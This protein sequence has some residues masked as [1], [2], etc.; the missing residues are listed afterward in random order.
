MCFVFGPGCFRVARFF[1]WKSVKILH[2]SKQRA[3]IVYRKRGTTPHKT[4]AMNPFEKIQALKKAEQ[5]LSKK[6]ISTGVNYSNSKSKDKAI[7]AER[8]SAFKKAGF[9]IK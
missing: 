8:I 9:N 1:L 2:K 5:S 7:Q 4:Q 3:I 6:S